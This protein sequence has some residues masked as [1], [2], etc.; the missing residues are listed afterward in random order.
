MTKGEE[1]ICKDAR[2]S[3]NWALFTGRRFL[4][5]EPAIFSEPYYSVV[6]SRLVASGYI[7]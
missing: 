4:G 1:L 5:G 2:L 3:L 6:Y 7:V